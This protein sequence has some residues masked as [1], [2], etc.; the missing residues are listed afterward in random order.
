MIEIRFHG[1]GGQGA[2]TAAV[3]LAEAFLSLG[4]HVQAFPEFGPERRGAPVKSFVR[5]SDTPI[6]THEPVTQPNFVVVIDESLMDLPEITEG[7]SE[8]K[9]LIINSRKNP[10]FF[11]KIFSGKIY[12]IDATKIAVDVLG[13]NVANTVMLGALA[14]VANIPLEALKQIVYRHF[15]QKDEK[16]AEDNVKAMEIAFKE[17]KK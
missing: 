4:K 14:A 9:T 6:T 12:T 13:K 16:I 17:N 2:K 15:K 8:D 1:R 7:L 11:R 3:M 5:A 10:D